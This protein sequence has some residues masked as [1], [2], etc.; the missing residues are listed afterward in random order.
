MMDTLFYG[1]LIDEIYNLNFTLPDFMEAEGSTNIFIGY[2]DNDGRKNFAQF[3]YNL[4]PF[5]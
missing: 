2:D 3:I 5:V 4:E 1:H